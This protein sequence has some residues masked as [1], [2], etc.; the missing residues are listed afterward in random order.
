MTGETS[1]YIPEVRIRYLR[2]RLQKPN[3]T[4]NI[5]ACTSQLLQLIWALIKDHHRYEFREETQIVILELE[6][7]YNQKKNRKKKQNSK[8]PVLV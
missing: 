2:R 7:L 4:K 1:R 6:H 5:T 3:C 8:K